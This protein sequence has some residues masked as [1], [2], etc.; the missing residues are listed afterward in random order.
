LIL[1]LI[2]YS[3]LFSRPTAAPKQESQSGPR[4]G[5]HI[6]LG[7][8][9]KLSTSLLV[10]A[11]GRSLQPVSSFQFAP[12][13]GVV[14][15]SVRILLLSARDAG[16]LYDT[17]TAGACSLEPQVVRCQQDAS[18]MDQSYGEGLLHL[19]V[20][21]LSDGRCR[22]RCGRADVNPHTSLHAFDRARPGD[23]ECQKG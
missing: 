16:P 6:P 2:I 23:P 9:S 5:L 17:L 15:P 8:S 18:W 22:C 13:R 12:H 20:W 19:A 14:A 1:I 4:K 3:A 21:R 10:G 11:C 7:G